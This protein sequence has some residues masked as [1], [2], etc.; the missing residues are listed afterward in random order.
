MAAGNI[1][2]AAVVARTLVEADPA[3]EM[4]HRLRAG[5]VRIILVPGDH[6][7]MLRG[8]AEELIVPKA[9]RAAEELTGRDG[10]R[11]MPQHVVKAGP[12]SPRPESVKQDR[13][14]LVRLVRVVLVPQLVPRM[15][16]IEKLDELRSQLF[17]LL[18][19]QNPHAC[20]VALLVIERHLIISQLVAFPLVA[21]L[22]ERKQIA[23]EL[24]A[25][26]KVNGHGRFSFT[27]ATSLSGLLHAGSMVATIVL[28]I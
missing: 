7:A 11:R 23:D 6:A 26:R 12:N 8:L 20:Q 27:A 5:P 25:R 18:V 16:R 9:D 10:E 14:G 3:G 24:V 13:I 15:L 19:R 17:D 21:G 22:G 1:V 4:G 28:R 2:D